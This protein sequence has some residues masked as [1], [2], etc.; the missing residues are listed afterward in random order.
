[1]CKV[2]RENGSDHVGVEF[3]RFDNSLLPLGPGFWFPED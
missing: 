3:K 2:G 1:M